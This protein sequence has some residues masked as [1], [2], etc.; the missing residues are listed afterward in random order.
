MTS[1]RARRSRGFSPEGKESQETATL[2][3]KIVPRDEKD[4][5]GTPITSA[6]LEQDDGS[7]IPLPCSPKKDKGI[8]GKAAGKVGGDDSCWKH[9]GEK[10]EIV[11]TAQSITKDAKRIRRLTKITGIKPF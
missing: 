2:T 4:K 11:G 5:D 9:V 10:V 8:A 6:F 7:L 3:G 1:G